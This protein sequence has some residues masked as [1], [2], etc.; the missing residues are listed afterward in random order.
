[1]HMANSKKT[2]QCLGWRVCRALRHNSGLQG[3]AAQPRPCEATSATDLKRGMLSGFK[4]ES[5]NGA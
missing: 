5:E 2:A 1:M 3:H 4:F